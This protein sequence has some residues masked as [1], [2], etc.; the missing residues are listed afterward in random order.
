MALKFQISPI[1]ELCEFGISS[2]VRMPDPIGLRTWSCQNLTLEALTSF[3]LPFPSK[4]AHEVGKKE[5][6]LRESP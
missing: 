4:K 1:L 5:M 6:H 3:F 2:R